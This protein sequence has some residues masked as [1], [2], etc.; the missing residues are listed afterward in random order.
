MGDWLYGY[1]TLNR[2][3]TSYAINGPNA[4]QTGCWAYDPFGNRWQEAFSTATS[5]PCASGAN[6]N[7][8]STSRSYNSLNRDTGFV[9]DAAGNVIQDLLNE[10]LY[11]PEGRLCAVKNSVGT[12]TQCVY[13]AEGRRVAKGLLSAWPASTWP[14]TAPGT[15]C[16]APTTA[17]G[18]TL[19]AQYLLD[20]GGDQVTELNG[21]TNPANNWQHSN[22]W[23]GG[24]LDAT[25]DT[26]GLHFHLADP[27]GTRR[28]QTNAVG[29]VEETCQGLP[30]GNGLNC[31]VPPGAPST[32]DD[33][34]E[35][36]F[37]G[38]E[39]DTESGN[40]YFGA[41]YYASS[42][43]RWMSPD[44]AFADQHAYNPQTWNLYAYGRNNPLGGFDPNGRGWW[45]D[46][47]QGFASTTYAPFVQAWNNPRATAAGISYAATH[48]ST[49]LPAIG[50]A[51]SNIV[52]A[53][54]H[55]DGKAI[56]QI[57][58]TATTAVVT[59]GA[60]G[61]AARGVSALIGTG[62]AAE[63]IS[64]VTNAI[65]ATVTRAIPASIE[66]TTLALPSEADAFVTAG[67]ALNG[68]TSSEISTALTIPESSS[69]FNLFEF[70]T[71]DGIASPINRLDPGFVGGG[72]TGGG[73]PEYV[74]P[75]GPIPEGATQ[76][77]VPPSN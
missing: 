39:R 40:D 9:Y 15:T 7:V 13:D 5:S 71:P 72:Q 69:G 34:T 62:M 55:G 20:Q 4:N 25:Y 14:P 70:P 19:S 61:L 2:L 28:V 10:Y 44:E 56:G 27:L 67:G 12:A 22:V 74:V 58:G 63:T 42:M 8:F 51:I 59:A 17:N 18:F 43:G 52:V 77:Y 24:H 3:S 21:S 65:P 38:K 23:P 60:V 11:D 36:H 41:R 50:N 35:H 48:L 66:A 47:G 46:F 33:A 75:N 16:A 32:A 76:T 68:M 6:D 37:T 1:D 26:L 57:V 73:L 54:A 31:I 29:L 30:F 64:A 49:T 53:A 45:S